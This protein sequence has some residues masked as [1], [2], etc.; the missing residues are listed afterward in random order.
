MSV[1]KDSERGTFYVQCRYKDWTGAPKKKTKRG[2]KTEKEARAWEYEFLRRIEGAPTMLF[3]EFYEIYAEDTKP[4]LRLNTWQT[5][6]ALIEG[7]IL[8]YLGNKRVNEITPLDILTWENTL[9]DMRTC[10]GLE[11]S[12]TYLHTICNQLSAMFN[13]AVRYYGFTSNPMTKVGKIGKKNANEMNFWTKDEYLQFSRIMM[14]KP[15]SFIAFEILYWC[16]I[17]L[18]ELLALTPNDFD[19]ATK[20][21]S[22]TKSYQRINCEDIITPPKTPKS[23]RTVVMPDF[24]MGEIKDYMKCIPDLSNN[25][26][27][28]PVTKSYLHHEMDRGAKAAGNKRIRIHDLRHSHVSLLIELGFSALAIAERL[29][30]ES[31][32]VT[33]RY[34]HLF[35]NKQEDMAFSLDSQRSIAMS[36]MDAI[37]P[38]NLD[39][40]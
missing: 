13:H 8:P 17:R 9:T 25:D 2:F 1:S 31:S 22:I 19:F 10:N 15:Q 6:A 21:V 36:H 23:V 40:S 3:S 39:R 27:L 33:L 24:L 11:Y 14:D 18:G 26:R 35:P 20:R 34:A 30:H 16:G 5:K 38:F 32:D 29:G 12:D 4:R 28:I 37:K 7:K